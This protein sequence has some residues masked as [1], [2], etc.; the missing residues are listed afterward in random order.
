MIARLILC[1]AVLTSACGDTSS[2]IA[3]ARFARPVD[4]A[5]VCAAVDDPDDPTTRMAVPTNGTRCQFEGE[6][7]D[8]DN[9]NLHALVIQSLGGEL[10]T[11]DLD[12]IDVLDAN[13]TVPGFTFLTVGEQPTGIVVNQDAPDYVYVASFGARTVQAIETNAILNGTKSST[14]GDPALSLPEGPI[15]LVGSPDGAFLYTA[16]STTGVIQEIAVSDDMLSLGST[17]SL[18]AAPAQVAPATM[19]DEY[20]RTCPPADPLEVSAPQL[21]TP[22]TGD[23]LPGRLRLDTSQGVLLVADRGQPAVHRFSLTAGGAT[24]LPSV[25]V[26][27]PVT[28]VVATPSVPQTADDNEAT[29]RYLYAIDATDGSVLVADYTDG[30]PTFGAVLPVAADAWRASD[31]TT[32]N[33]RSGFARDRITFGNASAISLEVISPEYDPDTIAADL[34]DPTDEEQLNDAR[35][36]NLRGVFVAVGLTDGSIAYL[37]VFDL[38]STCRG[39]QQCSSPAVATDIQVNIRRHRPRGGAF[40]S[41]PTDLIGQPSLRFDNSPGQLGDDGQPTSGDGPG[42]SPVTDPGS[43]SQQ[44]PTGMTAISA[45]GQPALLCGSVDPWIGL[46]QR[47]SARWQGT[48]PG[49]PGGLGALDATTGQLT[50]RDASFCARGVLG[51]DDV[52]ASGLGPD[53]PEALYGGDMLVITSPVPPER[54]DRADPDCGLFVAN[55]DIADPQPLAFRIESAGPTTL[56][57]GAAVPIT[58]PLG[59]ALSLESITQCFGDFVT[60]EVRT[61]DAY[62]VSATRAGVLHRVIDDG[63][64]C[65]VDTT[66]AIDPADPLTFVNFRAFEGTTYVNP[67]IA[68]EIE[69]FDDNLTIDALT[70]ALLIFDVNNGAT[71]LL[72]FSGTIGSVNLPSIPGTLRYLPL[73]DN[74]FVVDHVIGLGRIDLQPLGYSQYFR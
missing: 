21:P 72:F 44:C 7:E 71:P 24:A 11:V 47:W 9:D 49:T 58:Q 70:D 1:A 12:S 54:D 62:L 50:A 5:F 55:N 57:L 68:F 69:P 22:V 36:T 41:N 20:H 3:V 60:Y 19:I 56:E 2:S 53:D 16:L 37:D 15:D 23:P 67:A 29:H 17:L 48:I 27:V 45:E 74:L 63:G 61:A 31:A 25:G 26:G 40:V 35:P 42:I 18:P 59:N 4:V 10:G 30:S 65:R 43:G 39:G 28:D 51:T 64:A 46:R 8:L 66:R 73:V 33:L 34:C 32:A 52:T 13:P 14:L 6:D 38:D